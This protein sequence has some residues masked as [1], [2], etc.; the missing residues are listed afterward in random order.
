MDKHG[1]AVWE[2]FANCATYV[3]AG[4]IHGLLKTIPTHYRYIVLF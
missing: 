1:R 2:H 4:P 3:S